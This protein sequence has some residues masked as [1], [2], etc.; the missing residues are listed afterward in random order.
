MT[1]L[2]VIVRFKNEATY[3]DA[4]LHAVRE[5]RCGFP[6][7]IV[8]IDNSSTDDSL[9]IAARYADVVLN[10]TEYRPGAALNR[11]VEV[12]SG[13]ALVVLSAHALPA[14][15]CW[16][17][18]LTASLLIPRTLGAYGAQL[19]PFTSRFLD[20]RDLD[21]FSDLR[22]RQEVSDSDFWNANS[23]FLRS[24]WEIE[25]FDETVF[26]LEDHHWTK[27]ILPRGEYSVHFEPSALVYHYGH[28]ARNDRTF[29]PPSSLSDE[30]RIAT[31]VGVLLSADASWP[32]VMSAGLTLSSLSHVCGITE[33]VP[34]LGRHLLEHA[35]FD[36]RWRMAGALGRIRTPLSAKYLIH[37]L[38]DPSFYARDEAAWALARLGD[39]GVAELL[40]ALDA[41]PA[42]ARPFAALALGL[43]GNYD[44]G[45]RAVELLRGSLAVGNH[46]SVCDALYFLGEIAS[47]PTAH[48]LA[49]VVVKSLQVNNDEVVRAAAWCWGMLVAHNA[50]ARDLDRR[51]VLELARQYPLETIRFEAIVSLGKAIVARR[52]PALVHEVTR[53][54]AEDSS[55]RVRYGAMQTLRWMAGNGICCHA[56]AAAHDADSDF[57]VLFERSLLLK[58][59][60]S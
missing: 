14:N 19:Y 13:D 59:W 2:S 8:A 24:S 17:D 50:G 39:L 41:L 16:L 29:L 46:A 26:E 1:K 18:N 44:A 23:T 42:E 48:E 49:A 12:C 10:A 9:E 22:P 51:G 11:A 31:A 27:K 35:D 32:A 25:R 53:S 7:E 57:G 43:S 60:K 55:G 34:A 40:P 37:A 45:R 47:V 6:V 4:V 54:L 21:I 28:E 58:D 36:V 38:R 30:E 56:D 52:T 15:R 5:Q 33:A 20:K 3:L